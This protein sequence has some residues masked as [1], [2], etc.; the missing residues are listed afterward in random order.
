[1]KR[2]SLCYCRESDDGR[3]DGISGTF[4]EYVAGSQFEDLPFD[5]A[6]RTEAFLQYEAL[7]PPFDCSV[8]VSAARVALRSHPRNPASAR[9]TMANFSTSTENRI[10]R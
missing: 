9:P 2:V 1:M 7:S 3:Y 6:L 10:N 5:T 8:S 4:L